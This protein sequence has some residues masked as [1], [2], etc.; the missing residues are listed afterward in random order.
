MLD[1]IA[2]DETRHAALS[3]DY[4]AFLE[5]LLVDEERHEVAIR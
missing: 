1:V 5:G 4:G 2:E 3:I